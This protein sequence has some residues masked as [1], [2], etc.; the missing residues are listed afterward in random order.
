MIMKNKATKSF[1]EST[2]IIPVILTPTIL[3]FST[4]ISAKRKLTPRRQSSE[5][6]SQLT[7]DWNHLHVEKCLMTLVSSEIGG[8]HMGRI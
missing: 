4:S 8:S 5:T 3:L 1:H 2:C 7:T 6:G